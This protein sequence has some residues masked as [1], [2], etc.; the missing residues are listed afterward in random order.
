MASEN[1]S[2]IEVLQSKPEQMQPPVGERGSP[3]PK[4]RRQES[5]LEVLQDWIGEE[6]LILPD[7][8]RVLNEA[9]KLLYRYRDAANRIP[10]PSRSPAELLP[11]T[12]PNQAVEDYMPAKLDYCAEW[13][14]RWLAS[15]LPGKEEQQDKVLRQASIWARHDNGPF[16]Y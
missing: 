8:E 4:R 2:L 15:C 16:V 9:G 5:M 7:V 6:G 13:L 11:L 3:K 10:E 12:R 14:A 1:E